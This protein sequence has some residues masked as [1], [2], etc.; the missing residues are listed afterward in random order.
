MI[1]FPKAK[2]NL[3]LSVIEKRPDGFHNVETAM[4]SLALTDVLELIPNRIET[5]NLKSQDWILQATEK[6]TWYGKPGKL[7]SEDSTCLR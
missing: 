5:H 2:I 3:G 7:C 4:V 1:L 6:V